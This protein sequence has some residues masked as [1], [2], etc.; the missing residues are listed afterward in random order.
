MSPPDQMVIR[1]HFYTNNP[2]LTTDEFE[3]LERTVTARILCGDAGIGEV[4]LARLIEDMRWRYNEIMEIRRLRTRKSTC[5]YCL[6][7]EYC[8]I[9]G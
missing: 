6:N 9:H 1:F 2:C 8:N 3:E 4:I 7:K 5:V